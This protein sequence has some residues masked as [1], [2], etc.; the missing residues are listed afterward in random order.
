MTGESQVSDQQPARRRS[1]LITSNSAKLPLAKVA[2]VTAL[3]YSAWSVTAK[4]SN[5]FANLIAA[6]EGCNVVS[7]FAKR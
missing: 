4:K 5:G 6:P 7:P 2:D 3:R 1:V